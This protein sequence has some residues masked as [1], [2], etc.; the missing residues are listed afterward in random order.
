MSTAKSLQIPSVIQVIGSTIRVGH[1]ST[2]GNIKTYLRSPIAVAGTGMSV[3]DNNGIADADQLVVGTIGDP[4]TES[5]LVNG[6]V[7]VG[8]SITVA[9]TLKFAHDIDAEV[10]KVWERSVK[11]Y[12]AA[13]STGSLTLIATI[14]IHWGK[15]YTEYTLLTADTAYAYYAAK[16]TDGTTDS[17]ASG[18]VPSAG[19][20]YATVEPFIDQALDITN[21]ELDEKLLTRDMCVRWIQDA[22]SFIAQF[23]YQDPVSGRFIQKD[24]SW[25]VLEDSTSITLVQ[26]QNEYGLSLLTN[27]AKYTNSQKGVIDMR[28]GTQTILKPRSI[29][30]FDNIM[31]FKPHNTVATSPL[32]GATSLVLTDASEFNTGGGTIYVGTDTV[33]YTGIST[34]TLT[35]IPASGTG[36]ITSAYAVGTQVWQNLVPGLPS[37]YTI[38]NGTIKLDRPIS[39]I[40]AGQKLKLRYLYAI[41]RIT[42]VSSSTVIPFTNVFQLYLAAKIEKRK[43]NDDKHTDYMDQFRKQVL[44]N[45]LADMI[46]VNDEWQYHNYYDDFL[47]DGLNL[48][49]SYYYSNSF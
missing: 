23:T 28:I 47:F 7:T 5:V 20:N 29:D 13:T 46:P 40:Y 45:A 6:A 22:Q 33:T 9:N 39:S 43:G 30:E 44:S 37:Y 25:E 36:S 31:A 16:F 32:V 4:L 2:Q 19:V 35:G 38:F 18:Y 10:T 27:A 17:S 42:S 21:S 49:N 15:P 48:N 26:N 41:P 24:W 11:L 8:T 1:P 12:G 14:G 3:G 34:N